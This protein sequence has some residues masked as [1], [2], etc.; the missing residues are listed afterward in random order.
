MKKTKSIVALLIV[1]AIV[2][3]MIPFKSF[4]DFAST[5]LLTITFRDN[6]TETQG[7]VEYSVDD[8]A[9]W[10]QV[11]SNMNNQS[12]TMAGDNLRIKVVA[13]Q[14]YYANYNGMSYREDNESPKG[15]DAAENGSIVGGLGSGNGYYVSATAQYVELAGVEFNQNTVPVNPGPQQGNTESTI[16]LSGGTTGG[17]TE[18]FYNHEEQREET[19]FVP[20]SES[21]VNGEIAIND[22]FFHIEP[23]QEGSEI[24]TTTTGTLS[25]NYNAETDNGKVRMEFSSLF[26][27]RFVG[28]IKVNSETFNVSD[29]L[30][31]TNSA[32]WLEHYH[33]QIVSFEILVDKADTYNIVIN[34]EPTDEE[35]THIGNFLWTSDP[36]QE[37]EDSYIGHA[38]LRFVS[39]SY[40]VGNEIITTTAD[41]IVDGQGEYVE[42]GVGPDSFNPDYEG[43]GLTLPANAM[44]T[45]KIIP[46]YGYQVKYLS[47]N[48]SQMTAGDNISEFTFRADKGNFHLGAEVVA[49]KDEVISNAKGV[50]GGDISIDSN[51]IANGSVRLSVDDVTPSAEKIEAFEKQA[52]D[53]EISQYLNIGLEQVLYKGTADDVWS[54]EIED[55]NKEATVS[56]QL[57][58]AIDPENTVILHNIHDGDEFE[59]IEIESYD[60]DTNTATLKTKSFSNYA[61][62]TKTGANSETE[63]DKTTT[64]STT[65]NPKTGDNIT[66]FAIVF[67]VASLGLL[68]TRKLKK[69]SKKS[70]H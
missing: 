58:E 34:V 17:Y 37:G 54:N 14:G 52:G 46:E 67:V 61:I 2:I 44:V 40:Q 5:N 65:S 23:P 6:Y 22:S 63:T 8:G 11:T 39:A 3:S 13:N 49:V 16:N 33:G 15:L 47:S 24:P 50:E 29:Y 20:Y 26:I 27:N 18:T 60:K 35:T 32:Q 43:G 25:Y 41:E 62:A 51:E 53:Y 69:N 57:S 9:T 12:I 36:N 55:L 21:Y 30:D 28:T 64:G 68:V 10:T 42:Y 45:M 59:T 48:N 66:I 7:Y 31:Y 1:L 70:K 19:Q 4:A 56:L 38:K